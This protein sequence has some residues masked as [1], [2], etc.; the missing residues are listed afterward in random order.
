ME[1]SRFLGL[2]SI[3]AFGFRIELWEDRN[4]FLHRPASESPSPKALKP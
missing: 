4:P 2:V 3:R 1:V